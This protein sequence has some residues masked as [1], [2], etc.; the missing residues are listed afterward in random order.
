MT[1]SAQ[2]AYLVNVLQVADSVVKRWCHRQLETGVWAG[3][4]AEYPYLLGDTD[5]PLDQRPV[6]PLGATAPGIQGTL[7][8]GSP[9]ITGLPST[10][11]QSTAS[12]LAGM[13]VCLH[14][15][16]AIQ[17][18]NAKAIPAFTTLTVTPSGTTATMS[19]N[20]AL[21]G[22]FYLVF[23]LDVYLDYGGMAGQGV[24]AGQAAMGFGGQPTQQFIG[25][26]YILRVDEPLYA[27]SSSG[28]LTRWGAS[29]GWGG[30]GANYGI[31]AGW[32]NRGGLTA[33]L[34]PVWPRIPG[35][36]MVNYVA[37]YGIGAAPP[38]AGT[39]LG[40]SLPAFGANTIPSALT[41]AVNKVANAIRVM[42]VRGAP[43][44]ADALGEQAFRMLSYEPA[45]SELGTV[46]G[47][48]VR[49]RDQA[50]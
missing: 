1:N 6:R 31:D 26:D 35:S 50:V 45:G 18:Q 47:T 37:G 49:F 32:G 14:G 22:T 27:G 30:W 20:A 34:S 16:S 9:T 24:Q 2:D 5:L 12:M 43:P 4:T 7:T 48:L 13:P 23:G 41:D 10:G 29:P 3:A 44:Q 28:L 36:V 33:S 38:S 19:A 17:G 15:Q 25:R 8:Q 11:Y 39:P 42:T 46:R 40:G 21:S